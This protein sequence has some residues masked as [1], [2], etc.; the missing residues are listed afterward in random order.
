MHYHHFLHHRH[1]ILVHGLRLHDRHHRL[2]LVHHPE[3]LPVSQERF[4]YLEWLLLQN[5]C[6]A[7]REVCLLNKK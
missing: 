5:P 3:H 1:Q 4:Q 6:V 7:L 2:V